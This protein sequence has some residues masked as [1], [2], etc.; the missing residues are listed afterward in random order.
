VSAAFTSRAAE[1]TAASSSSPKTDCAVA[2]PAGAPA[3]L[4]RGVCVT[5]HQIGSVHG[6]GFCRTFRG[7]VTEAQVF[8]AVR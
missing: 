3:G 4:A 2:S 6:A 5:Q 7:V 8:G 1:K